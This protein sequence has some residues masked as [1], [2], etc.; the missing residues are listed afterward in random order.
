MKWSNE[1]NRS[2]DTDDGIFRV[3]LLLYDKKMSSKGEL[4]KSAIGSVRGEQ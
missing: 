2:T 4:G 1:F 3:I